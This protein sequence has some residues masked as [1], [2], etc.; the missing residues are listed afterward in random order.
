MKFHT[1]WPSG[2]AKRSIGVGMGDRG[3]LAAQAMFRKEDT[4]GGGSCP[5][6][7]PTNYQRRS[8]RAC[9]RGLPGM[10]IVVRLEW[11]RL[12][13]SLRRERVVVLIERQAARALAVMTGCCR[14]AI[15][16]HRS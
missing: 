2:L 10:R 11:P 6:S 3:Q 7:W 9:F 1:P 4:P 14:A 16:A 12:S 13:D 8:R 5:R 15:R